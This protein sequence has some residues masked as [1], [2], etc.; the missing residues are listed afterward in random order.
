MISMIIGLKKGSGF[1][2]LTM[3][4]DYIDIAIVI[5]KISNNFLYFSFSL[6]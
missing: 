2:K 5:Y 6:Y 4:C 3:I 1:K